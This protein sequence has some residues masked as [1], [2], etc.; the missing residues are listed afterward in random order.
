MLS[1]ALFL[2]AF[3]SLPTRYGFPSGNSSTAP[4]DAPATVTPVSCED[5]LF[6]PPHRAGLWTL[7]LW[8]LST[9]NAEETQS[10]FSLGFV[11]SRC[12]H[13]SSFVGFPPQHAMS[14]CRCLGDMPR[15]PSC[16]RNLAAGQQSPADTAVTHAASG[17]G[18]SLGGVPH[19][20]KHKGMLVKD[21]HLVACRRVLLEIA[22]YLAM[23]PNRVCDVGVM[24]MLLAWFMTQPR[25]WAHLLLSTWLGCL[26][27]AGLLLS[28]WLGCLKFAGVVMLA[29]RVTQTIGLGALAMVNSISLALVRPSITCTDLTAATAPAQALLV[30]PVSATAPVRAHFVPPVAAVPPL[31]ATAPVRAHSVPPVAATAPV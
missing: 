18:Y 13:V 14:D 23:H 21:L 5:A 22:V 20:F 3:G 29:Y 27:F 2:A 28:T 30:P 11:D 12:G 17:C 19:W 1:L 9:P 25:A 10:P 16:P 24:F 8:I 7:G 4:I 26:K 15:W 6:P 31:S